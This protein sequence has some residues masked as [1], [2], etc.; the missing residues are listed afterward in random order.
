MKKMP[1]VFIGHGSPMNAIETNPFSLG[2]QQLGKE[3]PQPEAILR[4]LVY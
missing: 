2:W 3:L 1:V 4:P